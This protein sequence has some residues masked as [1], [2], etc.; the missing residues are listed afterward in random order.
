MEAGVTRGV[1]TVAAIAVFKRIRPRRGAG[2]VTTRAKVGWV[3]SATTPPATRR[4]SAAVGEGSAR[5]RKRRQAG[6][7]AQAHNKYQ[8]SSNYKAQVLNN[9]NIE[10][11]TMEQRIDR[12]T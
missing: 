8:G 3:P 11:C 7:C 10:V 2:V 4:L 5:L 1:L 9:S 12:P 6:E